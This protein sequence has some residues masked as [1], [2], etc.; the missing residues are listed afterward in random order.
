MLAGFLHRDGV[1]RE[2]GPL[3]RRAGRIALASLVL[4]LSLEAAR[5]R[6]PVSAAS[7]ALL[8]GGGLA[9]YGAAAWALGAVTRDEWAG[10]TKK[11]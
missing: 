3:L 6:L 1:W 5:R 10:L 9:L 11:A 8:C 2:A 7:L 4:A